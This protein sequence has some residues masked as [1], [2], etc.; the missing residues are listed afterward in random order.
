MLSAFVDGELSEAETRE[1]ESHLATCADC[2]KYLRLLAA[3]HDELGR[4]L[5]DPPQI[6]RRGVMYK[7]GLQKKRRFGGFARWAVSAAVFCIALLGVIRLTGNDLKS[8]SAVAAD[9]AK[10]VAGNM[11]DAAADGFDYI[12]ENDAAA[13]EENAAD[14]VMTYAVNAAPANAP[15]PR[16]E[17]A[18]N[19]LPAGYSLMQAAPSAESAEAPP[20]ETMLTKAAEDADGS[21]VA[22]IYDAST[23][24]G[25]NAGMEALEE[26]GSYSAVG[27]LYAMPDGLPGRKWKKQDAPEGQLRWLVKKEV[28]DELSADSVFDEL[29][30]G[31]L[32]AENGL[33]IELIDEED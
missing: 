3:V 17:P 15:E 33:I 8:M 13:S 20:A 22:S 2:R 7:I 30:Y 24:R 29:Y 6:M 10:T 1:L 25:Y 28:M 26:A 19:G 32:L 14:G 21:E 11:A 16:P 4:D 9:T 5:P 18:E 23:L 27:I 31:D 12:R